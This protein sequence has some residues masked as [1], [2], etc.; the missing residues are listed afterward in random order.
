[1]KFY[2]VKYV[3]YKLQYIPIYRERE[4]IIILLVRN[5]VKLRCHLESFFSIRHNVECTLKKT[6]YLSIFWDIAKPVVVLL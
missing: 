4:I 2:V 3:L 5:V 6:L 1:M